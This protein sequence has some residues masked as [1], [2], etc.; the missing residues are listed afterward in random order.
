M[1]NIDTWLDFGFKNVHG[2]NLVYVTCWE[3]PRLDRDAMELT[4]DDTIVVLTS[5]GCNAIEY[6]LDSPKHIY[7]VDVNPRQNA[8]LELKIAGIKGL[9]FE[10]FFKLFGE[11][12]LS[13]FEQQYQQH[14]RHH[15]SPFAQEYWDQYGT[16]YFTRGRSLFFHGTTGIFA[17]LINFYIDK[18]VRLRPEMEELLAART[19]EQQKQVYHE[20]LE[21]RFWGKLIY[22]L[23]NND[24]TLWMLGVPYQQRRQMERS[25]EAGVADFVQDCCREVFTEVPIHDNYFWRV[26]IDGKYNQGCC[27]EYLKPE[28]FQRLKDGLID[29][30]SVHTNTVTGFLEQED[31]EISR[32]VLLD[33]MDWLSNYKYEELKREWQAIVDRAKSNTR[34]LFRSGGFEVDYVDP[35]Q[36]SVQGQSKRLGDLLHYQ[37]DRAER[38]HQQ[39][40]VHT[41]GSFYIADLVTA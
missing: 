17:Q 19:L 16:K 30:V 14:L 22:Q 13:D 38:L 20:K 37:Q 40:R 2:N 1:F 12:Q 7:A 25:L 27:P 28:P 5:A 31:V 3:D 15:L 24:I 4:E 39:D 6:A 41:Y 36:V 23:M 9:E 34:I 21:K 29:R 26:F 33:H 32:Y 35:I 18:I 10:T 8:L 11:G